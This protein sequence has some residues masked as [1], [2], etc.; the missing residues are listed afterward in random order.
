MQ[1]ALGILRRVVSETF[2]VALTGAVVFGGYQGF[3]YLKNNRAVVE[4]APMER[5]VSVVE[6]QPAEPWVDPL[7]IRGEGFVTPLRTVSLSA[8][9]G[10][11]VSYLHPAIVEEEGGIAAGEVLA[12]LDDS[13]ERAEMRQI[14]ANIAAAEAQA[15]LERSKLERVQALFDRGATSQQAL[16][17]ALAR[18]T[19]AEA[20]LD[21]FLASKAAIDVAI[22]NKIVRAPFDGAILSKTTE[23]GSIVGTG[24]EIAQAFSDN[25]LVVDVNVS[26]TEAALIPGLFDGGAQHAEVRLAFAGNTY[27]ADGK[28]SRV[29]PDIDPRTRTLAVRVELD[30]NGA[31]RLE[32]GQ[33]TTAGAPPALVNAFT[34]V[35]I[36]GLIAPDIYRVPS[37]SLHS[38]DVWL[39]VDGQLRIAPARTLHVDGSE[40][41]VEVPDV[42]AGARIIVSSIAAP[43]DGMT[44]R[45]SPSSDGP[46]TTQ[47][48]LAVEE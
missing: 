3:Q 28:V 21:G 30:D 42:P 6:T 19:D 11:M 45:D 39:L 20:R 46:T 4:V 10:G 5:P 32:Q 26:E 7:P 16:D 8:L 1:K 34:R 33:T 31:L 15:A 38:G 12:R 35:V 44:L 27:L 2:W 13:A 41:F 37:T 18:R 47:A 24:Q 29:A 23:V 22:E 48:A 43:V 14:E 40:S 17:E 25:H 36:D 9:S